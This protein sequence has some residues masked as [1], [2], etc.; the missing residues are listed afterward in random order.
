MGR[1]HRTISAWKARSEAKGLVNGLGR[2]AETQNFGRGMLSRVP[3]GWWGRGGERVMVL[4]LEERKKLRE[5][6]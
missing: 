3:L 5:K 6:G 4:M 2:P 1:A